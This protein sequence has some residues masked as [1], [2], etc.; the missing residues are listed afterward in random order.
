[1][2]GKEGRKRFLLVVVA[3]Q[4]IRND[5]RTTESYLKMTLCYGTEPV[6]FP[7]LRFCSGAPM[8]DKISLLLFRVAP[9]D[10]EESPL[11]KK[12]KTV[13]RRDIH[14]RICL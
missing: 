5:V 12:D 2:T 13:V 3:L 1:M 11:P 7:S 4:Q 6:H 10:C 9:L 14:R 8:T